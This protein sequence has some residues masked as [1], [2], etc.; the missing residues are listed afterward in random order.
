MRE[1]A[2]LIRMVQDI[3]SVEKAILETTAST[4][5]PVK[6]IRVRMGEPVKPRL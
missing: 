4:G 6:A 1:N 3:A 5:T 2:F